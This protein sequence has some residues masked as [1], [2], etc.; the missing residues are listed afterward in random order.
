[1]AAKIR[2]TPCA[3]GRC[4]YGTECTCQFYADWPPEPVV[5]RPWLGRNA[6]MYQL[7]YRQA[8]KSRCRQLWPHL[9]DEG[10]RL[11]QRIATEGNDVD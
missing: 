9:T 3:T 10:R 8:S 4:A 6:Q 7:G 2:E 5:I 1:M 11:A